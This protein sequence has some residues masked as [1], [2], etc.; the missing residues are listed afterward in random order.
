MR[1]LSPLLSVLLPVREHSA[2][3]APAVESILAQSLDDFECLIIGNANITQWQHHLPTDTRIRILQRPCPGIVS[4]LNTGLAAATGQ[5]IAR[6]DA[7]DISLPNRLAAQVDFLRS[8]PE[9]SIAGTRIELFVEEGELREGNKT[10]QNWLNSL[11]DPDSIKH[12]LYVE[13]PLPHPTWMAAREV[14]QRLNGYR[15]CSWAEDYD[16]LLRAN[17]LGMKMAKPS[18]TLFRW[19]DHSD[20]L[21]R[22]DQRYSS[23]N[24]QKARAWALAEQV[25][26]KRDVILCGTGRNATRLH[27]ALSEHGVTIQC[28]VEM[29]E[30]PTRVSRRHLPVITYS[31]LLQTKPTPLIISAVTSRGARGKLRHL[32]NGK[33]LTEGTDYVM[34]G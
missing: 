11:T 6:M 32:F 33:G 24:F 12:N 4:A 23:A 2:F 8:N 1:V 18:A 27:D 5:F 25:I 3:L 14:F 34:A 13:S 30:A 7:D 29:D 9:I 21:T 15:D 28:F 17:H 31:E 19:R 10:Y 26:Q 16:F 20:R 22:T